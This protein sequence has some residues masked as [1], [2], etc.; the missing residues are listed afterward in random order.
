MYATLGELRAKLRARLGYSGA[1]AAAGVSQENLNAIL[2]DAQVVL[3]WTHDWARLREYDDISIGVDQYLVDYPTNCNPERIKA[4]SIEVNGVWTPPLK[5]GIAPQDYTN[6][7][8]TSYPRA[9][10]PYDQ[11]E[12]FPKSDAVYSGRVFYVRNMERFTQDDDRATI[13]DAL[14]FTLALADGKG[15]YRHPDAPNYKARAE[16]LLASLKAK[17]WGKTVFNPLDFGDDVL[18][19]PRVV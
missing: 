12:F 14:I 15:H 1:G 6:Q 2:Q 17:N 10:E 13:D 18:A 11:I 4:I 7:D 19:K 5:K 16:S 8:S 3:Y 9:W